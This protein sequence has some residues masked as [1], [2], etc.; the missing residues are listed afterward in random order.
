VIRPAV[1]VARPQ[2][3]DR[4]RRRIDRVSTGVVLALFWGLV[5]FMLITLLTACD[6]GP[7][8]GDRCARVGDVYAHDRTRLICNKIHVWAPLPPPAKP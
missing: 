6:T 1:P 2:L 5:A 3:D 7:Q 4:P 8:V